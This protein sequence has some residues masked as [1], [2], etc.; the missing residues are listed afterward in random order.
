MYNDLFN[1]ENVLMYGDWFA[2]EQCPIIPDSSQQITYTFA[3]EPDVAKEIFSNLMNIISQLPS[4]SVP[5]SYKALVSKL[6]SPPA[7]AGGFCQTTQ[8]VCNSRGLTPTGEI[9]INA[10]MQ[11]H[12]IIDVDHMSRLTANKV[13]SMAQSHQPP[14]PVM[15]GHIGVLELA[16]GNRA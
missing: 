13:L 14:Y 9:L 2:G 1:Y 5:P 6:A 16:A 4:D 8:G 11:K 3:K 10:I 15:T 12:L 7:C